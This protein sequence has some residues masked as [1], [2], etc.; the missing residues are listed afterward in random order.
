M[1]EK[2][3]IDSGKVGMYRVPRQK[4]EAGV[5][6][7]NRWHSRLDNQERDLFRKEILK[8]VEVL[9][10]GNIQVIKQNNMEVPNKSSYTFLIRKF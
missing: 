1:I 3:G 6:R 8:Q 2:N 9:V 10:I 7:A 4:K 5:V